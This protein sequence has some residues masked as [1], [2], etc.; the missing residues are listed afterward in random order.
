MAADPYAYDEN[1]TL[2]YPKE[3]AERK[4]LYQDVLPWYWKTDKGTI[5][6]TQNHLYMPKVTG[7]IYIL[8]IIFNVDRYL[9]SNDDSSDDEDDTSSTDSSVVSELPEQYHILTMNFMIK[10]EDGK[11]FNHQWS[12]TMWENTIK[13]MEFLCEWECGTQLEF[14]TKRH[15]YP[16]MEFCM[17]QQHIREEI[18]KFGKEW[19]KNK[20][21]NTIIV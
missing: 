18:I 10:R 19:R 17:E 21:E 2:Y 12:G 13:P 4:K 20:V 5:S 8:A 15:S 3:N 16:T 6:E 7:K 14:F 9:V 11:Y 1:L